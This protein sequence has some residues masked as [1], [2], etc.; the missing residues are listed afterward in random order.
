M[1][2]RATEELAAQIHQLGDAASVADEFEE[3]RRDERDGF[4]MIQPQAAREP[5]LREERRP[6][7]ASACRVRVA[8]DA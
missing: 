1:T 6:D 4:G 8:S 5:L 3:L 2:S 7:A